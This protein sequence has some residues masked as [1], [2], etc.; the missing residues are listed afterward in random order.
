MF[1]ASIKHRVYKIIK[2]IDGH[3]RDKYKSKSVFNINV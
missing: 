3:I 2:Y 1:F